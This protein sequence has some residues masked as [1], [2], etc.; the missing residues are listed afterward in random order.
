MDVSAIVCVSE[1][2]A[3]RTRSRLPRSLAERVHVVV[4]GVDAVGF[5]P[6]GPR[7]A[8]PL[9][10]VFMGRI[11]RDK[12]ADVL[13]RAAAALRGADAEVLIV[14]RPGF[15]PNAPLSDY[16][17][18][19]RRLARASE[20][21]V[22]FTGFIPRDAMPAL[23]RTADV[24]VVP[25]RWPDPAPLTVGE[26]IATGLPTI[27][28]RIGGIPEVL[29]DAGILVPPDNPV[30]LADVLRRLIA[31]PAERARMS[32][33]ARARAETHDWSWSWRHLARVLSD[34]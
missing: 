30:A 9:R 10:I 23:L 32:V 15:D 27:A 3:E 17:R 21:P 28:S 20:L 8:G 14:G 19:L 4:N 12:G 26:A 22:R 11:I 34:L 1:S 25:S 31:D 6:G 24:F 5:T 29:G 16:E 18:E 33:A 13:L 2:L 7:S